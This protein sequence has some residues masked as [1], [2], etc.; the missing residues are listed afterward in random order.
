[1]AKLIKSIDDEVLV[2]PGAK[3]KLRQRDCVGAELF[4][5]REGAEAHTKENAKA[6]DALQ[7]ALWAERTRSLLVILQGIDTSGKDG[8]VRGVLNKCGPLGVNVTAFGKPSEEELAHDYLWRIHAAAPKK[9]M[10]GVFNRSHYED[11]L[12]VKVRKL[13]P[14]EA[15]EQRYDQ[16]NAFEKHL[17]ENGVTI[18][19]FMLHISKD[20]QRERLQER[21][22]QPEKNWKF[23]ADDLEDRKLWDDFSAAYETVLDRCSTDHAPWRVVPSDKKWR[24]NAIISSVVRQTLEDMN[25][26]YPKPDWKPSDFEIV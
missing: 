26:R 2:A 5:D 18:L 8:T 1:M 24:R 3:S 7:D 4:P 16:I 11:V 20:E 17:T 10:I 12:V 19:K 6:I 13:A 21:V 9:G 14:A 23:N 25:P 15:I 22:D